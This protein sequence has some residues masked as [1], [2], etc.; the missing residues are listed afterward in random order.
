M[1]R[2][3]GPPQAPALV[4][5]SD[6]TQTIH[7]PQKR[8]FHKESLSMA[9]ATLVPP[10]GQNVQLMRIPSGSKTKSPSRQPKMP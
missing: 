2:L 3:S 8:P 7:I 6:S 5:R 10:S 9:L 4:N 1:L